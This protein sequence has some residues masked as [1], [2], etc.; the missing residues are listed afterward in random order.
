MTPQVWIPL[1]AQGLLPPVWMAGLALGGR[2]GPLGMGIARR[3]SRGAAP[4]HGSHD[5][6]LAVPRCLLAVWPFGWPAAA[7]G[8]WRRRLTPGT[9]S[10]TRR[11]PREP[12]SPYPLS[13]RSFRRR[14]RERPGPLVRR[15]GG[16]RCP[17]HLG[18]GCGVPGPRSRARGRRG[19]RFYAALL[20]LRR[21][22]SAPLQRRNGLRSF[23]ETGYAFGLRFEQPFEGADPGPAML[24]RAGGTYKHIEVEGADGE[25]AADS[26]PWPGL[27][28]GRCCL[29]EMWPSSSASPDGSDGG[30]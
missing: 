19:L 28:G 26:G 16:G 22:G 15:A 18:S 29:S 24:I 12:R 13:A 27:G 30:P 5:L 3:R 20:G 9:D 10:D 14:A 17:P 11:L 4:R 6:W 1:V 2:H 23:E 8:G 7:G 21:M 25:L